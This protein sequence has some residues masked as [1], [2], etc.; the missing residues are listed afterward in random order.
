MLWHKFLLLL[1]GSITVL[2]L[3]LA[4]ANWWSFS[5]AGRQIELESKKILFKQNTTR[6]I[7]PELM[8]EVQI[9]LLQKNLFM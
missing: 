9:S 1:T 6:Y 2:C 4:L 8:P 3:G 7:Y 5:Q